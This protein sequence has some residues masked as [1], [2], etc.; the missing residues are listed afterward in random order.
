MDELTEKLENNT[1]TRAELDAAQPTDVKSPQW[2]AWNDLRIKM[3]NLSARK[4]D[5]IL[6]MF[7]DFQENIIHRRALMDA[8]FEVLES[9]TNKMGADISAIQVVMNKIKEDNEKFSKE[10]FAAL[11]KLETNHMKHMQKQIDDILK[12]VHGTNKQ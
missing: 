9:V 11:T 5:R 8:R 2:K 3:N 6:E 4:V 1:L 10:M 7:G 12:I